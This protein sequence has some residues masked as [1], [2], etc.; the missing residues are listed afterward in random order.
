MI[1]W[2]VCTNYE[3]EESEKLKTV[4]ELYVLEIHQKKSGLSQIENDGEEKYRARHS[5]KEFWEQKK[6]KI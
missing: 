3:Y 2:K 6:W 5:K 1:S 4:L